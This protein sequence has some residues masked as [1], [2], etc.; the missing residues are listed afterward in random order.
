MR[1]SVF[2][3]AFGSCDGLAPLVRRHP[4]GIAK[5]SR[6]S[7]NGGP[8]CFAGNRFSAASRLPTLP[9]PPIRVRSA[10]IGL[11]LLISADHHSKPNACLTT[12]APTKLTQ[13]NK[14]RFYRERLLS[15]GY[16]AQRRIG[17]RI[18]TGENDCG[19]CSH[20][21]ERSFLHRAVLLGRPIIGDRLDEDSLQ[22]IN[23]TLTRVR[24]KQCGNTSS[25]PSLK[26][27]LQRIAAGAHA[28]E[29]HQKEEPCE[30]R[31]H[32]GNDHHYV[33]PTVFEKHFS[34]PRP[35]GA[36]LAGPPP[37]LPARLRTP[38]PKIM[39]GDNGDDSDGPLWPR[40]TAPG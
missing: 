37:C 1:G 32:A 12:T 29:K 34:T 21:S 8:F 22:F 33:Y 28:D 18:A 15:H 13:Y 39:H 7:T 31:K 3:F 16:A 2:R 6:P 17:G 11:S 4:V 27:I 24:P 36:P 14:L 10:P 35:N 19:A 25:Q 20:C 30:R 38:P 9:L 40:E 26:P 23:S 5:A